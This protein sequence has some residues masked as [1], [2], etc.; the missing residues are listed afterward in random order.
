MLRK[1][2][3]VLVLGLALVFLVCV[4]PLWVLMGLAADGFVVRPV[5]W[6]VVGYVVGHHGIGFIDGRAVPAFR[7]WFGI[8]DACTWT[9]EETDFG[10]LRGFPGFRPGCRAH[11][12]IRDTM[13]AAFTY[14]F[15]ARPCYCGKPVNL[16][17]TRD[18]IRR[19]E[20]VYRVMP[21]ITLLK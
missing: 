14:E 21:D 17:V 11:V 2:L 8:Q 13:L 20:K 6:Y 19:I 12:S 5:L 15:K 7:R 9:Y 1:H 3:A 18:Q 10:T 16:V 4:L